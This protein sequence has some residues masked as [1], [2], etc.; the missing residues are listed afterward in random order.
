MSGKIS[1]HDRAVLGKITV[2]S[3]GRARKQIYA[4][5][6]NIKHLVGKF[7]LE[8]LAFITLTTQ[9]LI[10]PKELNVRFNSLS[11]EWKNRFDQWLRILECGKNG[12]W[13]IHAV[14]VLAKNSRG[15]GAVEIE[16]IFWKKKA[17]QYH[18]G[19]IDLRPVTDPL[20]LARY[21]TKSFGEKNISGITIR[22]ISYSQ[23]W[24]V[25]SA[26]FAWRGGIS[27]LY[28]QE[29]KKIFGEDNGL[30]VG[31]GLKFQILQQCI[32]RKTAENDQ[33]TN[34]P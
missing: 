6:E 27:K 30:P 5:R 33:A 20:G 13:H 29:M 32:A 12:R 16:R 26:D 11:R 8:N 9:D 28:R 7:G 2:T 25:I 24:R 10:T 3:N 31:C 14:A 18:F 1:G 34:S 23:G 19:R 4:V 15:P 21:L 17:P 22:K